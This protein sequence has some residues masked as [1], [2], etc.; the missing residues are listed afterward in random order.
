VNVL[1]SVVKKT[2]SFASSNRY[3]ALAAVGATRPQRRPHAPESQEQRQR[4]IDAAIKVQPAGQSALRPNKQGTIVTPTQRCSANT[5]TGAQCAQRTAVAHMC[6]NHLQRD[7]GVRVRPSSV[8]GAGRGLFASRHDGLHKGHRIPYT[9]DEVVLSSGA[10]G[11]PYVLQTKRGAGIDAARRNCGL[12]RWVNDPR[13]AVDEQGRARQANCEFVLHTPHG[14]GQRIAAVRT[15]RP[16]VRGE[17]LLV[18]Y[19]DAYWRFHAGTTSN[20]QRKIQAYRERRAKQALAA[21]ELAAIGATTE[22]ETSGLSRSLR[23]T[24][25]RRAAAAAKAQQQGSARAG[26]SAATA[27][28]E[29]SAAAA[30]K[31]A[32][33]QTDETNKAT[34]E[35]SPKTT[36]EALLSA[37]RRAAAADAEYQGWLQ[38]PPAGW[39]ANRGLLF[40]DQG[41]LRVPSDAALRTRILAEL[42]DSTTGA[43]CGRDRM[44]VDAQQRFDW[45][46][47]ASDVE[48]YVLTCDTCQR[49]KHSK[50]LKPGLLMPLPLPEEP[51]VHWTTDA[52]S[53]LPRSKRGF[54]AIQV[55]VDRMT[56]LKRFAAA[57]TTDGSEQLAGTT[58]RT[59][60]GPHGMP[61]SMVSDRDPRITA[62]FWRELSRVLGS[63]VSLSTAHHPQSDGQSEREIQTLITALRSYVNTMGND[64]DEY[65]PALELAFNS[66]QQASTGAA[67]FT[68]VYGTVARLPI[69]CALDDARPASLPAV[70]ERAERMKQ[71]FDLA[72][73]QAER[74]QAKQK[75]LADRYRRLLQLKAGDQVLLATEGLQLRSGTHKLTGRFIGPFRVVGSVND[76]AVTLDL[77]PLLGALHSTFNISRLK[78]YRDGRSAFPGRPQRLHQ[79]PAVEKDTNGVAEYEVDSVVAQR[80]S[81]SRR[82]LLIRWKGYGPEHDEWQARSE[83]MRTAPVRVAEYDALQQGISPHAARAALY[84]ILL[85]TTKPA[86]PQAAA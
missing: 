61:K 57:R 54:D 23:P 4:N 58:L 52:V 2:A 39:R 43:H 10:A 18:R 9:G 7:M 20:R 66:K 45:R 27:P 3:E 40:S 72:R 30:D 48:R 31:T 84:Q 53:G 46:G 36:T 17:E 25:S 69:D 68:L 83:L 38:S 85:H 62:R 60:I 82:E 65:L 49:N 50:Q 77:P 33:P 29:E 70:G 14:G 51:C 28:A 42:H 21:A 55:Y 32:L 86:P 75:R 35:N 74:A 73:S 71:A 67:P 41:R 76:N 24:A 22:D 81:G 26:R 64:W 13:G 80:G 1:H 63:E 79:P 15:L 11:G 16:I 34:E 59:I 56:K 12:G 6:W 8:Q 19:G 47:M 44:L 5:S 78:Q 37:V